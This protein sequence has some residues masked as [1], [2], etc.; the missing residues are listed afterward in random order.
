MGIHAAKPRVDSYYL[1]LVE[2]G[3]RRRRFPMCYII[4]GVVVLKEHLNK[5]QHSLS[6]WVDSMPFDVESWHHECMG[7]LKSFRILEIERIFIFIYFFSS[8][9]FCLIISILFISKC[10]RKKEYGNAL[11]S[12]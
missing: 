9:F 2:L 6:I 10:L 11:D 5:Q 4:T 7:K 3:R 8:I 12:Y 1:L